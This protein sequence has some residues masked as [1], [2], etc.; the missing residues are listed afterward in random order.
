MVVGGNT[1]S[2][3]VV[4]GAV[5]GEAQEQAVTVELNPQPSVKEVQGSVVEQ[6]KEMEHEPPIEAVTTGEPSN[7]DITSLLG[8]P[9]VIVV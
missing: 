1:S 6:P 5:P 2:P 7:V 4:E 3:P 9:I 8:A